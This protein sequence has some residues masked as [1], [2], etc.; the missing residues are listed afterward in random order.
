MLMGPCRSLP[1]Q[2]PSR[3]H[4]DAESPSRQGNEGRSS[5]SNLQRCPGETRSA[6]IGRLPRRPQ[7]LNLTSAKAG[8]AC[9]LLPGKHRT[10]R[11]SPQLGHLA[12]R[13]NIDDIG[14]GRLGLFGRRPARSLAWLEPCP[15]VAVPP[16]GAM[17]DGLK[18]A[19][20]GGLKASRGANLLGVSGQDRPRARTPWHPR[21]QEAR[22]QPAAPNPNR[23]LRR[24]SL[25]RGPRV[26]NKDG[27]RATVPHGTP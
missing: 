3:Q 18:Y 21:L 15:R 19:V 1:A 26:A 20:F 16:G 5:T 23:R 12:R 14:L 7:D 8:R 6:L 27:G 22:P 25:I 17:A 10:C 2:R 11:H 24:L 4:A 9:A 13:L